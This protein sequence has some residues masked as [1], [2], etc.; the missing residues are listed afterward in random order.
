MAWREDPPNSGRWRKQLW[1]NGRPHQLTCKGTKAEAET[2]EAKRRIELGAVDPQTSGSVLA[3]ERFS[4]NHYRPHAQAVLRK[5]TWKV[6]RFYLEHLVLH[7]GRMLL[8]KIR[9]PQIEAY[10]LKRLAEGVSK[11]TINSELAVLSTS[12]A[13]A[14]DT[15]KLACSHPKIKKFAVRAR[16]DKVECWSR[17]EVLRILAV[18]QSEAKWFFPLFLFLFETGCRKSEAVALGWKR[19]SFE[20]RILKIWNDDVEEYEVKSTEREVPLSDHLAVVLKQQK[21]KNGSSPW[22]FPCVTNRFEGVKGERMAE[23]PD[24]AW[25]R[26]VNAAGLSGGPHKARHTFAS[27]YLAAKPDLFRLGRILGHSH[28]R[29]TE[30]Y[31]HLLP[32]HLIEDRNV[33]VFDLTA[34]SGGSSGPRQTSDRGSD[35]S[36]AGATLT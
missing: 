21:L 31:S 4:A 19:V 28:S 36:S 34:A 6:R 5:S 15:L 11:T 14:R 26:V 20:R 8:T 7:F 25:R 10:K 24:N 16:K 22:V 33:V 9:E 2:Y 3:F 29:V 30:L 1:V 17:D 18:T 35:P 12:M 32:E 23:F 27:H 13:Y